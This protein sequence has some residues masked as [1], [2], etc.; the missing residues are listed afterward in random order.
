MILLRVNGI[1]LR[2]RE[3]TKEFSIEKER[4]SWGMYYQQQK[5]E[6][7]DLISKVGHRRWQERDIFGAL[8]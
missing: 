7:H 5:R 8:R 2:E 3:R 6:E 1:E 4:T